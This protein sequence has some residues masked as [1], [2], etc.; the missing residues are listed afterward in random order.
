MRK[1]LKKSDVLKSRSQVMLYHKIE[2]QK[3]KFNQWPLTFEQVDIKWVAFGH[4]C[5]LLPKTNWFGIILSKARYTG[6][7]ESHG[8][9]LVAFGI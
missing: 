9:S 8:I 6:I 5:T 3:G 4:L 1:I 2:T 7:I